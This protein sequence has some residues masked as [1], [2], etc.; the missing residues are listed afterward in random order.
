VRAV[1]R[2][3]RGRVVLGRQVYRQE[4]EGSLQRK[5]RIAVRMRQITREVRVRLEAS[6]RSLYLQHQ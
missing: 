3:K 4:E 6:L 2:R 1:I 5:R